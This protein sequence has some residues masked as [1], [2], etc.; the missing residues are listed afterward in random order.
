[1]YVLKNIETGIV[2]GIFNSVDTAKMMSQ[3]TDEYCMIEKL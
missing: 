3:L 1:M 2:I